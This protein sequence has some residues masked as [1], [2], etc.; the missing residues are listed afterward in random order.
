LIQAGV[1]Q[2]VASRL[3]TKLANAEKKL[4]AKQIQMFDSFGQTVSMEQGH[5]AHHQQMNKH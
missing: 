4:P 3:T 2:S 1:E 5:D